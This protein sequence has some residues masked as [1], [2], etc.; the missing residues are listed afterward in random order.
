MDSSYSLVPTLFS[1]GCIVAQRHAQTNGRTDRQ[2]DSLTDNNMMPIAG[3]IIQHAVRSAKNEAQVGNYQKR[4][5]VNTL[6]TQ[7][8]S[9]WNR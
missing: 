3:H 8:T 1:A 9:L 2:T 5:F 7:C 4:V 6:N